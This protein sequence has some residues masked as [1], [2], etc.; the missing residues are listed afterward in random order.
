M[1]DQATKRATKRQDS[2]QGLTLRGMQTMS[3]QH[4]SR[5]IRERLNE[6]GTSYLDALE[7][8]AFDV[9]T[10]P[11]VRV[12]AFIHLLD[13]QIGKAPEA[14]TVDHRMEIRAAMANITPE[15]QAKLTDVI[16][17]LRAAKT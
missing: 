9:V 14:I 5:M 2:S 15:I 13:R 12:M 16:T 3:G 11:N 10:P 7:A 17:A 1:G 4:A 8:I 6:R